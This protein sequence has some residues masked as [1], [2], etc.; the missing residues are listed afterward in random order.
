MAMIR[1]STQ[2]TAPSR[3][4]APHRLKVIIDDSKDHSYAT[5][6]ETQAANRL[7][8]SAGAANVKRQHLLNLHHNTTIVVD[9]PSVQ[10][11]ACGSTNF[12]WRGFFVQNNNV[13]IL[14]GTGPVAAFSGA[15]DSYWSKLQ[16]VFGDTDFH[17]LARTK[18][19][20]HTG[21]AQPARPWVNA[22]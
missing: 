18:P 2:V 19:D 12:S 3:L 6:A 22:Y 1:M 10:V 13:M 7:S 11:V 16:T 14:H 17:D 21:P 8:A 15:F 4:L 20:E 9:G 5:S